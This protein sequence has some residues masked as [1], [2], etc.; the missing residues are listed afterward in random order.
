MDDWQEPHES[1]FIV[2]IWAEVGDQ[3]DPE[4]RGHITHL[5]SARRKNIQ[6]LEEIPAFIKPY[7]AGLI[8]DLQ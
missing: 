8:Q 4:W 5:P 2:R 3:R 1:T 7:V 6:N